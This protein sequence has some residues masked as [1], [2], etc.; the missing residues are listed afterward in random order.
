[1]SS[2]LVLVFGLA[3][4]V[5]LPWVLL[6]WAARVLRSP[7]PAEPVGPTPLPIEQV[8]ADLRRL[9]RLRSS[10]ATRSSVWFTAVHLAYDDRLRTACR[11]LDIEYHLDGLDGV[12]LAL[13]RLRV[14]AA[15][16]SAGLV[17]DVDVPH[18]YGQR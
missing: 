18:R 9:S 12:D 6:P 3:A 8:A 4:T 11:Q 16:R 15:L 1:M 7:E 10:V 14:E 17:F 5:V 13:E 2:A